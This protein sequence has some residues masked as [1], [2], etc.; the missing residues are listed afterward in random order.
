MLIMSKNRIIMLVVVVLLVVGVGVYFSKVK[1]NKGYS[2]VY[3]TTGEVYIGKLTTFPLMKLE[4]GYVLGTAPDA[5]DPKKSNFQL[6]PLTEALWAPKY[7]Y[8]NRENVVFYGPILSSSS[9]GKTLLE[10][11]K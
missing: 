6:N 9:I 11:T 4:A 10:K 8:L 2:V 5:V 3:L 1:Q 7:L